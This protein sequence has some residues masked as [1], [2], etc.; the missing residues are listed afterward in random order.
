[1]QLQ[2]R[3]YL[4]LFALKAIAT[5]PRAAGRHRNYSTQ[6]RHLLVVQVTYQILPL[7]AQG[8]SPPVSALPPCQLKQ[9]LGG[10]T[11]GLNWQKSISRSITEDMD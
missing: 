6:L 4:F 3:T 7:I 5:F 8:P 11:C 9:H 10:I 1:M 2:V